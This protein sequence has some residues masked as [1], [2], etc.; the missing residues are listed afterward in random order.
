MK[1][2][3]VLIVGA[4][5]AGMMAA[6]SARKVSGNASIALV[7][8]NSSAGKKLR[9]TG[10]GRCNITTA[11]SGKDFLDYIPQNPKFLYKA[12]HQFNNEATISFFEKEGVRFHIEG[13][14]IY[15]N[16]GRADEIVTVFLK[17]LA[18]ERIEIIYDCMATDFEACDKIVLLTT[19][20][21]MRCKKLILAAGGASFPRTGSDWRVNRLL[22][23]KGIAVHP[24][25]PSL[26][27]LVVKNA[28]SQWAGISPDEVGL[29]IFENGKKLKTL[30]G[31]MIF[32]HRGISGP[33][34]MDASAYLSGRPIESIE[35]ALDL[36]PSVE[37]AAL[38][39][40]IRM[41]RDKRL[42]N[43]LSAHLPKNLLKSLFSDAED[44]AD[45]RNL[46]KAQYEEL[47]DRLKAMRITLRSLGTME[48]AI[49]TRGGVSVKEIDPATMALK[50]MKNLY[51]AGEMIDVDGL[52][53]GFNLQIAFSTGALAGR[54]AAMDL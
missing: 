18:R 42:T 21:K 41:K 2:H 40:L 50:R 22:S 33:V 39:E 23:E 11:V 37:R 28:R 36:I 14:K 17:M 38:I 13:K 54:S 51:V 16:S 19:R 29:T 24:P 8:A 31:E 32:T 48:E 4:G 7:E 43:L 44:M 52:T 49:V 20:G 3:D 5:P 10:G 27:Q 15:P 1:H 12:F 34:A 9:L 46:K 45:G 53:G 25:L 26:T 6:L 35:I 47:A 30:R